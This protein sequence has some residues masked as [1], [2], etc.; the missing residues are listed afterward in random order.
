MLRQSERL[1]SRIQNDERRNR[2]TSILIKAQVPLRDA[3]HVGHTFDFTEI[4]EK[5]EAARAAGDEL[6]EM[7]ANP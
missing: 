2:L 1:I 4:E 6:L 5:V 7:V 3:V